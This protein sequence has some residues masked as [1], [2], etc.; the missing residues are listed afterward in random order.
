MVSLE[1]TAA[2]L[3]AQDTRAR[4][5]ALDM[6]FVTKT[7]SARALEGIQILLMRCVVFVVF[8]LL[9]HLDSHISTIH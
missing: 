5:S 3:L 4:S 6:E 8:F 7:R 1:K 9:P 2:L